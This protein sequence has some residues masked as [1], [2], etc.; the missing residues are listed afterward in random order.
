M[1]VIRKIAWAAV[2]VVVMLAGILYVMYRANVAPIVPEIPSAEAASPTKPFVVKLHAQWC[3]VCM[4][5]TSVWTQIQKEYSSRV[6]FL[7]LDFTNDQTTEAS[8]AQAT[9]VGLEK[10]VDETGATGVVVVVNGRTKEI[11]SS[12]GGSRDM[13]EYRAA[14][15]AAVAGA[16]AKF[17][18]IGEA[19]SAASAG[20]PMIVE[21]RLF[22]VPDMPE[23]CKSMPRVVALKGPLRLELKAGTPL[24][25]SEFSVIAVD[26]DGNAVPDV[27]LAIDIEE[28][29]QLFAHLRG[30][31]SPL[32]LVSVRPG[33]GRLRAR[34]ICPGAELQLNTKLQVT[35]GVQ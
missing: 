8:R 20:R 31:E 21:H 25:F 1:A 13:G 19:R 32:R 35:P 23:L 22:S 12:I 26:A 3:P 11:M 18:T 16:A 34:T 5:T 14:I 17:V 33:T 9:R 30:D 24:T 6:N 7:V 10:I 28:G 4:A 2:S 15:D 27:P 29:P